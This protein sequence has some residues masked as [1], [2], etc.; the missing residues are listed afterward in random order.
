MNLENFGWWLRGYLEISGT[1]VLTPEQCKL[2]SQHLALCFEEKAKD[3][4]SVSQAT[5]TEEKGKEVPSTPKSKKKAPADKLVDDFLKWKKNFD[6]SHTTSGAAT[7][8]YY[9]TTV[10]C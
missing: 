6:K 5:L 2:V 3:L 4:K 9:C 10:S 7:D 1:D 8:T